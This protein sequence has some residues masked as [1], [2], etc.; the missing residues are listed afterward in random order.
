MINGSFGMAQKWDIQ[1]YRGLLVG[2]S[3][4]VGR[5]VE[6]TCSILVLIVHNL[7]QVGSI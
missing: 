4:E 5:A 2:L 3:Y 6:P 1:L 7:G